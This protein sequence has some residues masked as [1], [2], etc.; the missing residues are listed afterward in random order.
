MNNEKKCVNTDVYSS[1]KNIKHECHFKNYGNIFGLATVEKNLYL[2]FWPNR[3]VFFKKKIVNNG[4][5]K[6][7]PNLNLKKINTN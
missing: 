7:E 3:N 6:S 1:F 2:V 5:K 4:I